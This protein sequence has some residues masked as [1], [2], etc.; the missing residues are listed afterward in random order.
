MNR[1]LI[2]LKKIIKVNLLIT[3]LGFLNIYILTQ[4]LSTEIFGAYVLF[5][6]I[7]TFLIKVINIQTWQVLINRLNNNGLKHNYIFYA[8]LIDYSVAIVTAITYLLIYPIVIQYFDLKISFLIYSFFVLFFLFSANGYLI[9]ILRYYNKLTL[10]VYSDLF[11]SLVKTVFFLIGWYFHFSMSYFLMVFLLT[12][13]FTHVLYLVKS[14]QFVSEALRNASWTNYSYYI[15]DIAK[16]SV[17]SNASG[18]IRAFSTEGITIIIGLMLGNTFAGFHR[19]MI[20]IA[21]LVNQIAAPFF[22]VIY[23]EFSKA[24]HRKKYLFYQLMVKKLNYIFV[25]ISIVIIICFL[26][27]GNYMLL[28]FFS[29]YAHLYN[30][31]FFY[32]LA[33]LS[34]FFTLYIMP[35]LWSYDKPEYGFGLNLLTSLVEF[36]LLVFCIKYFALMAVPIAF[37][38]RSLVYIYYGNHLIKKAVFQ[39][40]IKS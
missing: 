12:V 18:T 19:I 37:I 28:M 2:I 40:S 13:C 1:I 6:A 39:N 16:F 33:Q 35:T 8:L 25:K 29:E 7:I 5:I 11:S 4:E 20:Q 17:Y 10:I 15:K 32:L 9:G 23:P 14:Y 27:F 34:G 30:T 22:Q 38:V 26:I 36:G 31:L 3:I 24:I 21:G